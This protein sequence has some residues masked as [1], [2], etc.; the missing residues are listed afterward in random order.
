[1]SATAHLEEAF[2]LLEPL[3]DRLRLVGAAPPEAVDEAERLLGVSFP[4]SYRAFVERAGAGSI[5]GREV[6]GVLAEPQAKGPPNVV[7]ITLNARSSFGLP[8]RFLIVVD[9]DDSSALALDSSQRR[10]DGECPVIHIWPGEPE[11]ELVDTEV[12][13]DFGSFFLR[14]AEERIALS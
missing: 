7:W 4:P 12:A 14:F 8:D 6:Y 3:H 5:L 2:R 11:S 10:F 1:M 13:S 9:L